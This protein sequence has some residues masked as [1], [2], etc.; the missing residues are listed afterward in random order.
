MVTAE[1]IKRMI[2]GVKIV[3][4]PEL[5]NYSNMSQ[6]LPKK[7]DCAILFIID[8]QTPT[9]SIGH[10]TSIMRN[11][12]KY[13]FFDSYGLS[14]SGDLE[15]IPMADRLKF[16]EV[17]D[18]LTSLTGGKLKH[19]HVRY[20]SWNPK[21]ATCGRFA[22]TRL[23]AFINGIKDPKEFYKFMKDAKD[24]YGAKSFDGLA[25]ILTSN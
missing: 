2:P 3:K 19:N 15:H 7:N 18:Y 20:Q 23:I 16:G 4:F 12:D 17:I 8:D 6:V 5:V 13:E 22:I 24:K 9:S 10:W 1:D 14:P 11:G 25:V 21:V